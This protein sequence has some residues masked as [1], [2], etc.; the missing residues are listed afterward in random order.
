[1][2]YRAALNGA[3]AVSSEIGEKSGLTGFVARLV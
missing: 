3:V 1:M 2:R